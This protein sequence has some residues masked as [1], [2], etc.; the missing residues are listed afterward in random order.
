[1]V[2]TLHAS[3]L[4]P[5]SGIVRLFRRSGRS[6]SALATLTMSGPI[7]AELKF[8]MPRG[9][10][11]ISRDLY[12]LHM[13]IMAICALIGAI[14]YGLIVYI[15]LNHRRSKGALAADF[16]KN[17]GLENVWT[18]IPLLFLFAMAVPATR[19]LIDMDDFDPADVTIKITASQWK[20]QYQYLDQGVE[21]YSNLATPPEQ[22]HGDRR[23]DRW[24]LLEVDKPLVLPINQKI[25]FLVTSSDVIHSWWVPELG[26]KRDAIPGFMHE[27]WARISEPGIY[28]GQCAELCGIH[29]GFMPIVVQA[30][31]EDEFS[32]WIVSQE[33][34]K[35]V[36]AVGWDMETALSQGEEIYNRYCAA[37]HQE[38][39]SGIAPMF[40]ALNRSSVVVGAPIERHI[41]LVLNGIPG[42]AMQ[43]IVQQLNAAQIAAVVTYE[44]NAW[45]NHTGDLIT[46]EQVQ[47]RRRHSHP[48][49][50]Q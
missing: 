14:L 4:K 38:N 27:A 48:A 36:S 6:F 41:D 29:H 22:I 7:C 46:P 35:P 39:G 5:W 37:C 3:I 25:R 23:K 43:A 15:L 2:V 32:Q 18:L 49:V 21:F 1:M 13:T 30:V 40:P 45:E 19:V 31:S 10:T 33:S 28:R 16:E 8:N 34:K 24:Y 44:R 47:A 42:S 50:P 9:V 11:P 12:D 17:S 20:W 26:I